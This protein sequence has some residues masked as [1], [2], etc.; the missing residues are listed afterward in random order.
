M[1]QLLRFDRSY[2]TIITLSLFP[3]IQNSTGY[4]HLKGGKSV[5][6]PLRSGSLLRLTAS[7]ANNIALSHLKIPITMSGISHLEYTEVVRSRGAQL[8]SQIL[9]AQDFLQ[10]SS[11][12]RFGFGSFVRPV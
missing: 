12:M 6:C 7:N 8:T 11:G 5:I 9:E 2:M 4:I 10:V 3:N 1:L